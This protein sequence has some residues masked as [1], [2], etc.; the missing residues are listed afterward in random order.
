[1]GLFDK[2]RKAF[3]GENTSG[4]PSVGAGMPGS[5]WAAQAQAAQQF[6]A[7]EFQR[8]GY[9]DGS[10]ASVSGA[11]LLNGQMQADH[12]ELQAYGQELNRIFQ[13]GEIGGGVITS[14]VDTGER[15]AGQA[16]FQLEVAISLPD[17]DPYVASKREMVPETSLASYAVG[18]SHEVRVDPADPQK[19]VLSS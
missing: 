14:A 3:T 8:A 15:T 1:M 13:I 7:Q 10:L 9:G 6:V 2:A 19:F 5:D 18:S 4:D 16:W 12:D 17:R 11:G